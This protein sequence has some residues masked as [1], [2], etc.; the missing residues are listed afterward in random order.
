[1]TGGFLVVILFLD[2]SVDLGF[3]KPIVVPD[4]LEMLAC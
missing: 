3:V 1:M 4:Q 2:I